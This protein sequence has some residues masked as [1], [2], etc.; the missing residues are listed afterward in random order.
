MLV[1]PTP[2]AALAALDRCVAK[3]VRAR[4]AAGGHAAPDAE[5]IA[6]RALLTDASPPEATVLKAL[7]GRIATG[8]GLRVVA[9]GPAARLLGVDRWGEGVA[10]VVD[11]EAALT[12]AAAGALAVIDVGDRPWWGRLLARPDLRVVGALPD[13]Q[14]GLPRALAVSRLSGGP[15]GADRTFWV[16]DSVMGDTG[17]TAA[18]AACGLSATPLTS[19]GGLKLFILAGY[20]QPEDWRLRDAPGSLSGVIGSAPVF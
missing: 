6:L 1:E 5:A 16:T 14:A 19:G 8:A 20:V 3:A 4:L 13:N 9:A 2:D 7:L 12:R 11:P 10:P 15:T 18:L 17:V